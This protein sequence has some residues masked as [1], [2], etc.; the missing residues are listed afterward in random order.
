VSGRKP[1]GTGT[2]KKD[3]KKSRFD[4]HSRHSESEI[5]RKFGNDAVTIREQ[6]GHSGFSLDVRNLSY[7]GLATFRNLSSDTPKQFA[8]AIPV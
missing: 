7:E 8:D 4:R 5:Q 1:V 3:V 6:P 2:E